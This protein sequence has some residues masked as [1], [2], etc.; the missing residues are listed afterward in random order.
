MKNI[1]WYISRF[2]TISIAEILFRILQRLSYKYQYNRR[3]QFNQ[4]K[5]KTFKSNGVLFDIAGSSAE[6]LDY[7]EEIEA[8]GKKFSLENFNFKRT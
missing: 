8:F 3:L 5:I 2:R 6:R 7:C 1:N 4:L